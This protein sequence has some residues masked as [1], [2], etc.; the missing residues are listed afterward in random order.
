MI[1][2]I[3]EDANDPGTAVKRS[4]QIRTFQFADLYSGRNQHIEKSI[5]FQ[6]KCFGYSQN[7]QEA[8]LSGV[9]RQGLNRINRFYASLYKAL[10]TIA[11]S[12]LKYLRANW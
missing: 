5:Y 6:L 11:Q 4:H 10:V 3:Q 12:L 9:M 7:L 8:L 2:F 1:Q